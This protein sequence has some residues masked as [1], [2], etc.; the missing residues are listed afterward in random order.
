MPPIRSKNKKKNTVKENKPSTNSKRIK[1]YDYTSW[2]KFDIVSDIICVK[3]YT[4]LFEN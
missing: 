3:L 2:D 1:S 4:F